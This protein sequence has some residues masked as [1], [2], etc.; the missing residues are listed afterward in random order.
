M[1]YLPVLVLKRYHYEGVSWY[2]ACA[3]WYWWEDWIWSEH[4]PHLSPGWVTHDPGLLLCSVVNT[5]LMEMKVGP[6]LLDQKPW[7]LSLSWFCSLWVWAPLWRICPRGKQGWSK[8]LQ[9][10]HPV[11]C[12]GADWDG[13]RIPVRALDCPWSGASLSTSNGCPHSVQ[14]LCWVWANSVPHG[15]TLSLVMALFTLC[16]ATLVSKRGQSGRSIQSVVAMGNR[17]ETLTVSLFLHLFF[18]SKRAYVNSSEAESRFLI[19]S[20]SVPLVF[21]PGKRTCSP[22]AGLSP[23]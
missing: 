10:G 15:C 4:K 2:C 18:R 6:K 13:S 16:G 9:S 8:R 11:M 22:D 19:D 23:N 21:K 5:T 12:Q 3:C 1:K 17:S 20:L 7:G 14:M